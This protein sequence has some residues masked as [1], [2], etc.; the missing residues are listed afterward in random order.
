MD[1]LHNQKV[2]VKISCVLAVLLFLLLVVGGVGFYS[3]QKLSNITRD[4]YDDRLQPIELMAEVRLLSKDT[5]AKLL[6]LIQTTDQ[7]KQ[8]DILKSIDENTKNIN[9]L[10]EQYQATSL[11]ALEKQKIEELQKEL[12]PYR[13]ARAE[14]IKLVTAG[15]QQEAFTLFEASKPVFAKALSVRADISKYNSK[16]GKELNIQGSEMSSLTSKMILGVTILAFLLAGGLGIM[17]ARAISN[18]LNKIVRAVDEIAAGDL[19]E[20]PQGVMSQDEIGHLADAI[21]KMR[22]SLR[23]LTVNISASSEKVAASAEELTASSEQSAQ[24]ATQVAESIISVA[25]GANRQVGS[26]SNANSI[27]ESMSVGIQEMSANASSMTS[28]ADKTALAATQGLQ[29]I[30]K[31]TAQIASIEKT[32]TNSAIIVEKLGERSKDIGQIVEAISSIASQT[33]LLALNAAIEAARAGEQGRG[34]AVVAEEVR[35]LA[36]QSETAAKEIAGL[37]QEIQQDTDKAVQAMQEGTKEVKVGTEVVNSAGQTF[38]EIADS[39]AQVSS[40]VTQI[41]AA[42]GHMADSS[43][44]IVAVIQDIDTVT[45]STAEQTQTVSAATEEQSAAMEEIASSST[46]LAKL[47]EELQGTI[48]Q[49]TT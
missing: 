6:E 20:K 5:E 44:E 15:K 37:I 26:V 1:F 42:I 49:F 40:Q 19:R 24:A 38:Q 4:L 2:A 17:L 35:K 47:A 13:Q 32:V 8:Q 41:A 18:P 29:A 34:F 10:Q 28:A 25:N 14:I 45:K 12:A 48:K 31:A 36:E 22:D 39:I 16:I 43:Q 33:N 7:S 23:Q 11:D 3:A 30:N 27:I 46:V 21:V 9:K